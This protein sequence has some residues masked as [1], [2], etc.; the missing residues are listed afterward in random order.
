MELKKA[1]AAGKLSVDTGFLG[2]VVP[3]PTS[4]I[5]E[6]VNAGIRGFK[7]FMCHSGIDDFQGVTLADLHTAMPVLKVCL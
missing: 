2:G 3:G 6:L 1:A 7:C 5:E 4:H